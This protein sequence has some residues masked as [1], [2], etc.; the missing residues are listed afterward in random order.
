MP[1]INNFQEEMLPL[2][3]TEMLP[4]YLAFD[5]EISKVMPEGSEDF[6]QYRPLGISCA[7][8]LSSG[9]ELKLW[10]GKDAEGKIS[11]QTPVETLN[12]LI[13]YLMAQNREGYKIVTWNGLGFDFDILFEE[14]DG[15][16]DCIFLASTHYDMMF[17]LFCEKGYPLSLDKAARGMG[18]K[19]KTEGV[20]GAQ[21]PIMWQSGQFEKVLEYLSQDV[22]T[23]LDLA[24]ICEVKHHL[25]WF[26]NTGK[27]QRLA[28]PKGW[29]NVEAALKLP[30]PDNSWM[31][32]PWLRSKFTGWLEDK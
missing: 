8:T 17:H 6:R 30:E 1:K 27:L 31:S 11:N 14:T 23:T 3:F 20:D 25:E 15:N 28:L 5:L 19:G 21:V 18:L 16:P 29:L 13:E 22:R 32:N 10:Y 7:A 4:K 2:Q 26:S 24:A 12:E 9:G